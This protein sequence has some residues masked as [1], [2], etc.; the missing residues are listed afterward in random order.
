MAGDNG[1]VFHIG[2]QSRIEMRGGCVHIV[3]IERGAAAEEIVSGIDKYDIARTLRLADSV[4]ERALRHQRA[5][6]P[7]SVFYRF[8]KPVAVAVTGG[9]NRQIVLSVLEGRAGRE[10]QRGRGRNELFYLHL[11]NMFVLSGH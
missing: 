1:V 11:M 3:V 4:H 2:S 7:P 6:G 5:S 10:D 8:G 9:D